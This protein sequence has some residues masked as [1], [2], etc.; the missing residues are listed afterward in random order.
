MGSFPYYFHWN[1]IV[2]EDNPQPMVYY[3]GTEETILDVTNNYWGNNFNYLT[4]LYPS[5]IYTWSPVWNP[6]TKSVSMAESLYESALD[7]IELE[8]FQWC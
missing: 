2:D 6:Y 8:D 5:S 4:D 3:S 7:K 1:A